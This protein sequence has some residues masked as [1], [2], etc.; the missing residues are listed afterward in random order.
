MILVKFSKGWADEFDVYG[1][2][3]VESNDVWQ[4][5]L[6]HLGEN[7]VYFGTNEGWDAS[8]MSESDFRVSEISDQDAEVIIRTLGK[9]WGVFPV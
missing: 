3:V 8:E 5:R 6:K 1:F 7:D 9:R 4:N 2:A